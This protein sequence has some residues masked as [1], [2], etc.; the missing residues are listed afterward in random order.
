MFPPLHRLRPGAAIATHGDDGDLA[1]CP[2][3]DPPGGQATGKCRRSV[4]FGVGRHY[5]VFDREVYGVPVL[6]VTLDAPWLVD[7]VPLVRFEFFKFSRESALETQRL[8]KEGKL[9]HGRRIDLRAHYFVSATRRR[10]AADMFEEATHSVMLSIV[11]VAF[12]GPGNAKAHSVRAVG[13]GA[14]EWEGFKDKALRIIAENPLAFFDL[15]PEPTLALQTSHRAP[16]LQRIS[17][18]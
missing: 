13:G 7:D 6:R 5:E 4:A 18:G 11:P 8:A 15:P 10:G 9:P 12:G 16:L 1:P 14:N 3:H 2:Q 17:R